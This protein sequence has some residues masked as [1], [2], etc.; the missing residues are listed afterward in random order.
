MKLGSLFDGSGGFPLAGSIC[1]IEPIWASEVE[2]YPIAVTRSRFPNMKHL[3]DISKINGA[4]IEPVDVITFGSPCTDLSIAGKRAG[5]KHEERGDDE[6]T[7]SGL[8]F[9]A[10]RI[11]NEMRVATGGK[12]P[13]YV[14]WENVPGAFSSNKGGDFRSV[15]E[16]ICAIADNSI[17]IPMPEKGKWK[18]SG[19]I[20]GDG[21]SVVWR[22]HDAQYWRVPQRRRRIYVV[23]DFGGECAREILFKPEGVCW[24]L[25]PSNETREKTSS[26]VVGRID[27][28]VVGVDGY[29]QTIANV[30]GSLRAGSDQDHVGAVIYPALF[31]AGQGAKAGGIAYSELVSPTLKGCASGLN[32]APSM[33]SPVIALQANGIDRADTA[34]CNGAGWREDQS[35]TLNTIDR[36]AVCYV[37]PDVVGTLAASGA[38]TS[39]T[40]GQGNETDLVVVTNTAELGLASGDSAVGTLMACCATKMWLGHQ[41]AF[42]GN[43]HIVRSGKKHIIRRLLPIECS[44]LQGFPDGWAEIDEFDGDVEFWERARADIAEIE[45]KTYKPSKNL[46]R[47]YT[48]L[49]TDASEYKM[50]GNGIALPFAVYVMNNIVQQNAHER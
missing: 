6:T 22:T 23:A 31:M 12:Y 43:Y 38:G 50:W 47:W 35:Y 16:A 32:Q 13:R 29:N 15:L 4:L 9:E 7:R 3:G 25:A 40:A 17:S 14:I 46:A 48:G 49:H 36:H 37:H 27:R 33:V 2:P 44:R 34:G 1:G 41:E 8:F 45:G 21:Y 39:R 26:D 24:N 10:I 5:M 11:I 30:M 19:E 18:L 42:S 28:S 20:V